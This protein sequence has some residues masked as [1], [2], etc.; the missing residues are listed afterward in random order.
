[1]LHIQDQYAVTSPPFRTA[2]TDWSV[3]DLM[4]RFGEIPLSRIVVNPALGTATE[5]DLLW[6]DDHEDRLCE[7]IDGT[8]LEKTYGIYESWLAVKIGCELGRL[9]DAQNL[10][11]LLSA[12]G[13]VRL[14][15]GHVRIPDVTFISWDC[16]N[17]KP[18][19]KER[20]WAVAPDLAVE[21]VSEGNTPQEM[22]G[23]LA[24]YFNAGVRLV[25]YFYPVE[26]AVHVYV[27]PDQV[28]VINECDVLDGGEVL[29]GFSLPLQGF[30]D[31]PQ[32]PKTP[33]ENSSEVEMSG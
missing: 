21:V 15:P 13:P 16:F 20:I 18:D 27:A 22:D 3:G 31:E 19:F 6:L 30:F 26:R 24:D 5:D 32:P 29:P 28:R 9:V 23:K 7:L 1:M 11:I 33:G 8:L 4:R 17:K 10:G 12:S 2:A 14:F 25:W